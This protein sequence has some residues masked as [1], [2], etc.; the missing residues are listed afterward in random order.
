MMNFK[1][2]K[3]LKQKQQKQKKRKAFTLKVYTLE[4]AVPVV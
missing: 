3:S 1:S 4:K 2:N